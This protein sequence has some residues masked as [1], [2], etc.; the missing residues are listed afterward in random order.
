M[1]MRVQSDGMSGVV[2]ILTIEVEDIIQHLFGFHG[3]T[4]G[5]ECDGLQIAVDGL[6]EVAFPTI[7]IA[8]LIVF[9]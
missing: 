8:L 1:F 5:I 7:V 2:I 6:L 9:V 4:V 3:R